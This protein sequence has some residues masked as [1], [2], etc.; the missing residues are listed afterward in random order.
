MKGAQKVFPRGG[1]FG[2]AALSK[3]RVYEKGGS[4]F[5]FS[6]RMLVK[7]ARG[8]LFLGPGAKEG[9]IV[10][11]GEKNKKPLVTTH[12]LFLRPKMESTFEHPP[13]RQIPDSRQWQPVTK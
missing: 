12:T 3:E 7:V 1:N 5:I 8:G 13:E 10:P 2:E 4:F 11:P 6:C 9:E